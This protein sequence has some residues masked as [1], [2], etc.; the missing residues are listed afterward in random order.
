MDPEQCLYECSTITI[1]KHSSAYQYIFNCVDLM[2]L[3]CDFLSCK[4][5]GGQS[6]SQSSI[7]DFADDISQRF[8]HAVFVEVLVKQAIILDPYK[9]SS[10]TTVY[11]QVMSV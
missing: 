9:A 7:F 8:G 5:L 1:E 10:I 2:N 6:Q 4:C 3:E 11:T